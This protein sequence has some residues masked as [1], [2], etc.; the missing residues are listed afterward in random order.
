MYRVIELYDNGKEGVAGKVISTHST[1]QEAVEAKTG[2][3]L[4][5]CRSDKPL[6]ELFDVRVIERYIRQG[7]YTRADYEVY[8]QAISE[9]V[10]R[11]SVVYAEIY[12]DIGE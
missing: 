2:Q 7:F 4:I 1:R 8:T 11:K 6:N 12:K 3:R 9:S 5:V 10:G